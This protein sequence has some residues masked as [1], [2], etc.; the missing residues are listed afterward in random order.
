MKNTKNSINDVGFLLYNIP[1]PSLDYTKVSTIC[2]RHLKHYMPHIPVAVC[3]E[4]V[5][6]ADIHIPLKNIKSNKRTYVHKSITYNE[7]W[8]NLTRD[9]SLEITPFKRTVLLDSDYIVQSN[10]LEILL[11]SKSPLLMYEKIYNVKEDSIEVD[12]LGNTK[13][14]LKWATV[15]AFDHSPVSKKLFDLWSKVLQN[16]RYYELLYRWRS[17]GTVWNDK[18]ITIA[19]QQLVDYDP[20]SKQYII[21]WCQPFASFSCDVEHIGLD[22]I[23]LKDQKS[24]FRVYTDIHIL[25]KKEII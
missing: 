3:G 13:I 25:N 2:V 12:Y 22:K 15:L 18:A 17:D 1:T 20:N 21:P 16:Y 24:Q 10:Q 7:T 14:K 19:Y 23:I 8:M 5:E 9:K 11:Q 4:T 6:G